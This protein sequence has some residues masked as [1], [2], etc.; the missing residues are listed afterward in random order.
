VLV[1]ELQALA[2]ASDY[3]E[4]NNVLEFSTRRAEEI[5]HR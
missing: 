5:V 4:E 3:D 2:W 1:D